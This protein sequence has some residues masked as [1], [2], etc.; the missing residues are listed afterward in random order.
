VGLPPTEGR[1]LTDA[2]RAMS[3]ASGT[4]TFPPGPFDHAFSSI[5]SLKKHLELFQQKA[6]GR[7]AAPA[8]A[9]AREAPAGAPLAHNGMQGTKDEKAQDQEAENGAGG[10]PAPRGLRL[11]SEGRVSSVVEPCPNDRRDGGVQGAQGEE[12]SAA[13]DVALK[14]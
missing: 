6:P 2:L 5:H 1:G 13:V 14:L 3:E 11:R 10:W 8:P 4:P 7:M 9:Q 12:A